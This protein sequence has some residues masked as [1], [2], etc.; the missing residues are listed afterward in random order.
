MNQFAS[1]RKVRIF[2]AS[3][4]D[5]STERQRVE[6]VVN[7]LNHST[8]RGLGLF[9]EFADWSTY[10]RP[11]AADRPE[12]VILDQLPVETWDVF[13]GILWT[14]F[15]S[16]SG[17]EDPAT[18]V[19]YASG[20]EEEFKLAYRSWLHRK[21]PTIMVYRCARETLPLELDAEQFKAVRDFFKQFE[22]GQ[23]HPG[24]YKPFNEADDLE[25]QV[26][27]HLTDLLFKQTAELPPPPPRFKPGEPYEVVALA[28]EIAG[29]RDIARKHGEKKLS[30]ALKKLYEIVEGHCGRPEWERVSWKAGSR[31]LVTSGGKMHNRTAMAG[32]AILKAV[33][34]YNLDP[35][36]EIKF[37]LRLAAADG[38]IV[39]EEDPSQTAAE[40]VLFASHV[41]EHATEPSGFSITDTVHRGLHESLRKEFNLL[42]RVDDQRILG[43][44]AAAARPL[45]RTA[46]PNLVKQ[47]SEEL[48]LL[49]GRSITE[50]GSGVDLVYGQLEEFSR[51]FLTI[52]DQWSAAYLQQIDTWAAALLDG[53]KHFW[54]SVQA[55]Y[56]RAAAG[57]AEKAQWKNFADIV[58][59]RRADAV[60]PLAQIKAHTQ[61][62]TARARK[63][64]EPLVEKNI[65]T[66][67]APPVSPALESKIRRLIE[68]DE[69]EEEVALADLLSTE[70]EAL[71]AG[72]SA[73]AFGDLREPLLSR[74]WSLSDLVLIDELQDDRNGLF[75]AL[76]KN[77]ITRSRYGELTKILSDTTPPSETVVRARFTAAGLPFT[78]ADLHVVWRSAL[79]GV[80]RTD[81]LILA[82]VKIPVAVLWR[83]IASP[84]IRVS[85]LYAVAQRFRKEPDDQRK[86]LFDCIHTRLMREVQSIGRDFSFVG[87]MLSSFFA[88]EL[89][90]QSPYFERLDD[91]L[92]N[93]RRSS[94]PG[95]AAV[96][97]FDTLA[98]KLKKV[99]ED[100]DNPEA[101][102]PA[103]IESLPLP[104]QR[105]LAAQGMYTNSLVLHSDV[106]IAKEA[107]RFVT[108]GNVERVIGY[109]Q[110][111]ESV[112]RMLLQ[113]KE[114]FIRRSTLLAALQHPKCD[115]E[116][117]RLNI[118]KVGA[119]GWRSVANNSNANPTIRGLAKNLIASH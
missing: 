7:R 75:A 25:E 119:Q 91:L 51:H 115:V 37:R 117:A 63:Q 114:F 84:R 71:I 31:V 102:V 60:V 85:A 18:G 106:R 22:T 87:K 65:A 108:M 113:R 82:L 77:P 83:T 86:I 30:P 79:V 12:S 1:V 34:V 45:P 39:W 2:V 11:S 95:A 66:I 78:K 20:T 70:R 59:S 21:R 89:F 68:A 94:P 97:L 35:E 57:S 40:A 41:A 42:Q 90:V 4:S 96:E 28:I 100:R 43:Y 58:G 27:S 88:D 101:G 19:P 3:P 74:L 8:A 24:I 15:G 111:N 73:N 17:A 110:L 9:L 23:E 103:G 105:H 5:M 36:N 76:L 46:V 44:H 104:V 38:P 52:D 33:E 64:V 118:V 16:P 54:D 107:A 112:L 116:F 81:H 61:L 10:V 62:T 72:V 13:I 109:R 6:K 49:A 26:Q 69:L 98:E 99:R 53:E 32:I 67:S 29:F 55:N 50:A 48:K 14:R 56:A 80:A 47:A 92:L 93:F